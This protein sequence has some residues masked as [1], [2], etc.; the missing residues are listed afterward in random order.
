MYK[1]AFYRT[2]KMLDKMLSV[3]SIVDE[4]CIMFRV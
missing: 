2:D 1:D 4:R 3:A